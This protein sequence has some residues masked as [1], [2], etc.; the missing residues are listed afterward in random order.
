VENL[1]PIKYKGG[2]RNEPGQWRKLKVE[3]RAGGWSDFKLGKG[4]VKISKKQKT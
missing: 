4:I 3:A 1:N 2:G